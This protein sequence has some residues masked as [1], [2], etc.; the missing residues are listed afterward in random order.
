MKD[1]WEELTSEEREQILKGIEDV[2]NGKV[3][4]YEE[5]IIKYI[6]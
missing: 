5:F 1:F 6:D 4:D 2:K 3:L